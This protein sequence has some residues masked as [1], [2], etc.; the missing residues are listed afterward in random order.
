MPGLSLNRTILAGISAL[1]QG[2]RVTPMLILRLGS[3]GRLARRDHGGSSGR[4]GWLKK[5]IHNALNRQLSD[6]VI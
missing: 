1:R 6:R 3:L 2:I 5:A 4:P